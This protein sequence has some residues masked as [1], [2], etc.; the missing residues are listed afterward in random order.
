MS[1]AMVPFLILVFVACAPATPHVSFTPQPAMVEVDEVFGMSFRVEDC[2]DSIASFQLYMSFDPAIVELVEASEGSLYVESG[3]MTWFIEDEEYTGF[4][5][6]FDTVFGVGTHILAPGELLHLTFRALQDGHTQAHIDTIRMTDVR[7]NALPVG[8]FEHGEI[9]VG[10]VGVEEPGGSRL[11]LGAPS[12]NPSVGE[13]VV[14][15]S[16]PL[17]GGPWRA[18]VYDLTGRLVRTLDISGAPGGG[19]LRWDGRTNGGRDAPSAVYFVRVTGSA[20]EA[21]TKLVRIR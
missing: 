10:P 15:F 4:W 20:G 2:P 3:H 16:L 21:R 12:P 1:L 9:F 13:T 7:R 17:D 8:G 14:P 18:G 5:H 19:E 11:W 6:F